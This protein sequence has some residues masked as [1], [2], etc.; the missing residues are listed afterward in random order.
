M[1]PTPHQMRLAARCLEDVRG[2]LNEGT[3]CRSV[4]GW[5]R[6]EAAEQELR[7]EARRTGVKVSF[8]RQRT[9]IGVD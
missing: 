6:Y 5:L 1:K 3:T 9:P 7:A 2:D 4:A 8:L